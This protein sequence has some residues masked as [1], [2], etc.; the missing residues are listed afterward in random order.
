MAYLFLQFCFSL[1]SLSTAYGSLLSTLLI[2][3][4]QAGSDN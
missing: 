3:A 1:L 4:A 2:S